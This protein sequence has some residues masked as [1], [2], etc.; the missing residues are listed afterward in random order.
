MQAQDSTLDK[1][2]MLINYFLH[3]SSAFPL[4]CLLVV[5]PAAGEHRSV[6]GLMQF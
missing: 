5:L 6:E 2:L 4:A 3:Q 1:L